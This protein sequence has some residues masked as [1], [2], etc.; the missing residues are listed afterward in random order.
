MIPGSLPLPL[1]EEPDATGWG[2][3]V[4]VFA[5]ESYQG[6]TISALAQLRWHGFWIT[7]L[8]FFIFLAAF[9]A[10]KIGTAPD[11]NI[12]VSQLTTRKI[13]WDSYKILA[14]ISRS[15][16]WPWSGG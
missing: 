8:D 4:G 9:T 6:S 1:S 2:R 16:G 13:E 7:F 3:M 11:Y 5:G 10:V 12:W 14:D 15:F